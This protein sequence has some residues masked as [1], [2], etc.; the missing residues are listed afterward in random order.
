[1]KNDN[2]SN[3]DNVTAFDNQDNPIVIL[4]G[5]GNMNTAPYYPFTFEEGGE[6]VTQLVAGTSYKFKAGEEYTGHPLNIGTGGSTAEPLEGLQPFRD[7]ED[8]SPAGIMPLNPNSYFNI[9]VPESAESLN[10]QCSSHMSMFGTLT[11]VEPS[12]ED[13][14]DDSSTEETTD[15]GSTAPGAV[16]MSLP[17]EIVVDKDNPNAGDFIYV[18]GRCYEKTNT[19]GEEHEVTHDQV[20]GGMLDTKSVTVVS[21][22]DSPTVTSISRYD[23]IQKQFTGCDD[24]GSYGTRYRGQSKETGKDFKIK[25]IKEIDSDNGSVYRYKLNGEDR[26]GFFNLVTNRD[27]LFYDNDSVTFDIG[28]LSSADKSNFNVTAQNAADGENKRIVGNTRSDPGLYSKLRN[29]TSSINVG[30]YAYNENGNSDDMGGTILVKK[31]PYEDN[32]YYDEAKLKQFPDRLLATKSHSLLIKNDGRVYGTGYNSSFQLGID[33]DRSNSSRRDTLTNWTPTLINEIGPIKKISGCGNHHCYITYDNKLYLSGQNDRG[34]L[35][36][37]DT[38]HSPK[39]QMAEINHAT[40]SEEGSETLYLSE[41][42]HTRIIDADAGM[43]HTVALDVNQRIWVWGTSGT[44]GNMLLSF[45]NR[46]GSTSG[47]RYQESPYNTYD[48][49]GAGGFNTGGH[50]YIQTRSI[51]AYWG[52]TSTTNSNPAKITNPDQFDSSTHIRQVACGLYTTFI[53]NSAGKVYSCGYNAN[54]ELGQSSIDGREN[55]DA[56]YAQNPHRSLGA[57]SSTGGNGEDT[58]L[59]HVKKVITGD[60]HTLLLTYDEKLYGFGKNTNGCLGKDPTDDAYESKPIL[61]SGE[62]KVYAASAGANSTA[63][64]TYEGKVK[65]AGSNINGKLGIDRFIEAPVPQVRASTEEITSFTESPNLTGVIEIKMGDQYTLGLMTDGQIIA[66]GDNQYGS[67]GTRGS[68]DGNSDTYSRYDD[69]DAGVNSNNLQNFGRTIDFKN[70]DKTLICMPNT[71]LIW[72]KEATTQKVQAAGRS[73]EYQGGYYNDVATAIAAEKDLTLINNTLSG[74]VTEDNATITKIVATHSNTVKM[75]NSKGELWSYGAGDRYQHGNNSASNSATPVQPIANDAPLENIVNVAGGHYFTLALDTN[76]RL[77]GYG[78]SGT[79]GSFARTYNNRTGSTSGWRYQ[80]SPYNTYDPS[81]AGGFNSGGHAYTQNTAQL[82]NDGGLRVIPDYVGRIVD[83][84]CGGYTTYI[85]NEDGELFS[86]GYNGNGELGQRH[87]RGREDADAGVTAGNLHSS[88]GQV[89]PYTSVLD[90]RVK[91]I[92]PGGS[93]CLVIMED[94]KLYGWG[95]NNHYQLGLSE[96]NTEGRIFKDKHHTPVLIADD[97]EDAFAG[98]SNS[99]YKKLDGS[100]YA[101]G[102]N[103]DGQ[104]AGWGD[105]RTL[106]LDRHDDIFGLKDETSHAKTPISWFESSDRILEI[107]FGNHHSVIKRAKVNSA[108]KTQI[109]WYSAGSNQFGQRAIGRDPA[110]ENGKW[111]ADDHQVL[112]VTNIPDYV[113][114]DKWVKIQSITLD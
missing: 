8:P 46:T 106:G 31:N 32:I 112:D 86:C 92:I 59:I 43:Y 75:I 70:T 51:L 62:D 35:G 25:V 15:T 1:M 84:Q 4:V 9:T 95:A 113:G 3:N 34:Q 7:G 57:V 111:T 23:V 94:N 24:C 63:Y 18:S 54:G 19:S 72:Q 109:E 81:G 13:T 76:N 27:L 41:D 36:R 71:T 64:I 44:A 91:K 20:F 22:K 78:T 39:P 114:S 48:P 101:M 108:E 37:G 45:N 50:A 97:V 10:Y 85:L 40:A 89:Y 66:L 93:H 83:I 102:Y 69:A 90:A 16:T 74:T 33:R 6:V 60:R 100:V 38:A 79:Y 98:T 29:T 55:A 42:I 2:N 110:G 30:E 73:A 11:V 47:W 21:P 87:L 96:G 65:V 56:G 5:A 99:A 77:W 105:G 49:S 52:E 68:I 53:L 103:I 104:I 107:A 14:T 80:A 12:A 26:N 88:F 28:S 82:L 17:D 61:L 67:L 58:E